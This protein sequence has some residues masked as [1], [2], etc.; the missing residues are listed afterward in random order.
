MRNYKVGDKV[1]LNWE[2]KNEVVTVDEI[3]IREKWDGKKLI[4]EPIIVFQ[5]KEDKGTSFN[6]WAYFFQVKKIV[7][8]NKKDET[9]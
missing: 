3:D 5:K 7:G 4:T 8:S 6:S 9:N 2:H 1:Q